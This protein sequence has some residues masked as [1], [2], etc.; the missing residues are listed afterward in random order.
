MISYYSTLNYTLTQNLAIKYLISILKTIYIR[1]YISKRANFDYAHFLILN[2]EELYIYPPNSY[3]KIFLYNFQAIYVPP[4]SNCKYNS[5]N[6]YQQFPLCIYDFLNNRM[7]NKDGNYIT[8]IFESIFYEYIF[9]F[10][11]YA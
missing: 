7:K 4:A 1:R 9:C 10:V 5:S 6:N 11:L 3:N 8:L 2:K